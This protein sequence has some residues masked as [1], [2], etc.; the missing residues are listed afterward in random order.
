MVD[1]TNP[2]SSQPPGSNPTQGADSKGPNVSYKGGQIQAKPLDWLGMHFTG[3]EAQKLWNIIIQTVSSQ[4]NKDKEKA[5]KAI[6]KL[7]ADNDND[8]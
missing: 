3:E 8:D 4:I 6:K 7:R 1:K 5:I 2:A